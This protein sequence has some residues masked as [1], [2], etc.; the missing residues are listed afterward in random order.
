MMANLEILK[1]EFPKLRRRLDF[2]EFHL[3][4]EG[5]YLNVW[6]NISI[7]FYARWDSN[8]MTL[9]EVREQ[10]EQA[11]DAED[12]DALVDLREQMTAANQ[13][14]KEIWAELWDCDP[15]EV[16]QLMSA[17]PELFS[18][19]CGR[20][21]DIIEAYRLGRRAKVKRG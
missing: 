17:A 1:G 10:L 19:C 18:W 4:L 3:D 5:S 15:D 2:A 11:I 21:V 13:R 14:G 6:L 7:E 12:E 20:T 16:A 8:N 9:Q